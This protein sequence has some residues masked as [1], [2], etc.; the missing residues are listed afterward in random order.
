MI[1]GSD[2]NIHVAYSW[3]NM[4][5][6]KSIKYLCVEEAWIRGSKVCYG[7]GNNPA[8]QKIERA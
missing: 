3:G 4:K 5:F 7:A 8:M 2:G 1:Q 6:G